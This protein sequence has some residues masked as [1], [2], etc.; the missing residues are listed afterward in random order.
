MIWKV[1]RTNIKV[2]QLIAAFVGVLCGLSLLM[3][4]VLFYTDIQQIFEDK[5]GFWKDEYI[6]INKDIH[7][8]DSF[9]QVL[10]S[11]KEKPVFT[12]VEIENIKNQ[13]F[14]SDVAPFTAAT[15]SISVFTDRDSPLAGFYSDIFFEAVPD[16]YIDVN[17][18]DWF[19]EEDM[20]FV[21]TILPRAYLNLYNFGFAQSQGLPQISEDGAGILDFNVVI[22]GNDQRGEFKTRIMGFSDRLNTFLVPQSFINWGNKNF[23]HTETPEPGRLIVIAPDPSNQEMLNFFEDNEY[24]VSKSLLSNSK[25]LA[26]LKITTGIVLTIGIIIITLAFW[27]MIVS[28]LLLLER[29]HD[30]ISKLSILGYSLREI[31]KPYTLL[32]IIL[33]Y[34]MYFSAF[35]PLLIFRS[36]Y[37]DVLQSIGYQVSLSGLGFIALPVIALVTVLCSCLI[38][39]VRN[40]IKRIMS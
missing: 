24:V 34:T 7:F 18:E 11:E 9:K 6:V 1:L 30:N 13:S 2:S 33:L 3:S 35:I 15:F 27:L 14:I 22:Y 29:N 39:F 26:F 37:A 20:Q 19:W 12:D 21:P 28:L 10:D 17:T 31:S 5:E 32:I 40:E 8:S 36:I 38:L 16:D 23:G 4:A 25:A